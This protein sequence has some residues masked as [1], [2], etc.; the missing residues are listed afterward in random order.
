MAGLGRTESFSNDTKVTLCD[1]DTQA[2]VASVVG[3]GNSQFLHRNPFEANLELLRRAAIIVPAE[4][5]ERRPRAHTDIP[6]SRRALWMQNSDHP[7]ERRDV[8]IDAV[9]AM[10]KRLLDKS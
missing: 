7:V 9:A 10:M 4:R 5:K 2:G 6:F 1:A 8:S 3:I